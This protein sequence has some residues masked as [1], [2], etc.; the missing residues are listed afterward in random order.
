MANIVNDQVVSS[1]YP[2]VTQQDV[3][4]RIGLGA[5]IG[6]TNPSGYESGTSTVNQTALSAAFDDADGYLSGEFSGSYYTTPLQAINSNGTNKIRTWMVSL[7]CHYVY[8]ARSQR[9]TTTQTTFEADYERVLAEINSVKSGTRYLNF[10]GAWGI[11]PN[12][13]A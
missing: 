3:V 13:P 7:I 10:A 9:D 1:D 6:Y 5:L 11:A 4:N 8:I 12:A 2:F